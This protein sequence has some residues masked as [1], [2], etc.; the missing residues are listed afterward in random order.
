MSAFQAWVEEAH[1]E[2][3]PPSIAD[4]WKEVKEA[5]EEEQKKGRRRRLDRVAALPTAPA[6][7][8]AP[9]PLPV[10]SALSPEPSARRK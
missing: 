4:G 7:P 10:A 9:V 1:A 6:A 3:K 5:E 2:G 8:Q